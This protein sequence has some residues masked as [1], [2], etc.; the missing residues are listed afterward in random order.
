[1]SRRKP[2]R[3]RRVREEVKPKIRQVEAITPNHEVY[4]DSI[5]NNLITI[6]TGPAGCG[7]AQPIDSLVY[8]PSGPKKM[9]NIVVGEKVCTP[10]GGTANVIAIHPQGIKDVY[11]I[12]FK[13]GNSVKCCDDHLWVLEENNGKSWSNKLLD[14]K[15]IRSGK[16]FYER[17]S[18]EFKRFKYRIKSSGITNFKKV[19]LLIDPYILGALLG[20]GGLTSNVVISN[21]PDDNEI[22]KMIEARL[23][24][25]VS[26]GKIPS[27]KYE[28]AITT[29]R[30][31]NNPIKDALK[32]IGVF[33]KKS[34]KK[35]IPRCYKY[36]DAQTRIDLVRGLMDTDGSIDRRGMIEYSSSSRELALDMKEVLESLGCLVSIN[37]KETTCLPSYRLYIKDVH[38]IGL[39]YLKRKSSRIKKHHGYTKY[40]YIAA[41][42]KADSQE[43]KCITI[44]SND[45]LYI[46]DNF[47]AT[48]NSFLATG[49]FA[50]YLHEG[51]FEQIVVTRPLVCAGKEIGALPGE[52][53]EKIAPYL[54]PIE[55][56]LKFFLGQSY[57]GH[58]LNNKQIRYEPLET[59]RGMTFNRTLMLLDEAQNCT[60][61]QIKMFMTRIGK[62]SKIVI[63]G[64]SKQTDI[65]N[66]SGLDWTIDRLYDAH[67]DGLG[68]CQ[69]GYEDIQR[70]GIIGDILKYL[71][72]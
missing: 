61:E 22:I 29:R 7:K 48:H 34:E 26:I 18:S 66:K 14:T 30:G 49:M 4:M 2:T 36:N 6:C 63:N 19:P 15:T 54:K 58:Y 10:G 40:I 45:R 13:N 35:F 42:K 60:S 31:H 23:P 28:W 3:T 43:C 16:I 68:I 8:T 70:N 65:K 33:G 41:I 24:E 62:D 52:L 27:A 55:E 9:G 71:E 32:E 64:D 67:V 37:K 12:V 1:M 47:V 51:E 44:D 38:D 39:F 57:Y 53:G 20:D 5:D 69:L 56:N 11:E 50:N 17:S 72:D 46:T 59:M 25:G 21:H